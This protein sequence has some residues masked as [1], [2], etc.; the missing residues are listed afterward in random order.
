[1]KEALAELENEQAV[2]VREARAKV[3]QEYERATNLEEEL[4]DA[5]EK[6]PARFGV[7]LRQHV[8]RIDLYFEE[9]A[10]PRQRFQFA[11]GALTVRAGSFLAGV[12]S[13]DCS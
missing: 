6:N 13:Y 8:R 5:A 11:A 1:L 3:E 4:R 7:L 12:E 9:P 10:K 2:P